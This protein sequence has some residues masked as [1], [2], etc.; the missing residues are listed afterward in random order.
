[1]GIVFATIDGTGSPKNPETI[2]TAPDG[3]VWIVGRVIDL[4]EHFPPEVHLQ[5]ASAIESNAVAMCLDETYFVGP[6]P[7]DVLLPQRPTPWAGLY[8]PLKTNKK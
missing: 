3:V 6:V 8:Y 5:G 4:G 2:Q 7:V 1:M